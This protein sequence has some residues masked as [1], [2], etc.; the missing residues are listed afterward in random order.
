MEIF[1]SLQHAHYLQGVGT[2]GVNS[3]GVDFPGM[4]LVV[5]ATSTFQGATGEGMIAD[6]PALEN[7]F[8]RVLMRVGVK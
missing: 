4:N 7:K 3:G 1:R 8:S 2:E 6:T 5:R